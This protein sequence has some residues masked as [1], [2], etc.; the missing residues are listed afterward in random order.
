MENYNVR[1]QFG[2]NEFNFF[3]Q[4]NVGLKRLDISFNGFGREGCKG[5]S[6]AL[7]KNRTLQ[8][9]DLSYNRMVDEDIEVL[10][11]GLMENE[12][13]KT[14]AVCKGTTADHVV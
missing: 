2:L 8:E 7:K 12:A 11:Q 9:L 4:K 6:L 3:V 13:L 10:A 14:L 1:P 5:L